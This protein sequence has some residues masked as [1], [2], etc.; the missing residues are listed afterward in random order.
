VLLRDVLDRAVG[1]PVGARPDGAFESFTAQL[2]GIDS[3][4][5]LVRLTAQPAN[6]QHAVGLESP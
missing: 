5:Q 6:T 3:D 4:Q 2:R 1:A